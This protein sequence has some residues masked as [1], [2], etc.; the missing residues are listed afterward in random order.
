MASNIHESDGKKMGNSLKD[1]AII[2]YGGETKKIKV[3]LELIEER[4]GLSDTGE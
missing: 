2:S 3:R 4:F 1:S